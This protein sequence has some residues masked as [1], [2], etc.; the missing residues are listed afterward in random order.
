MF[1][2]VSFWVDVQFSM[3][4][5]VELIMNIHIYRNDFLDAYVHPYFGSIANHFLLQD[6]NAR[7]QGLSL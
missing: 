7:L 4:L 1:A 3:S 5:H 2:I 6:D